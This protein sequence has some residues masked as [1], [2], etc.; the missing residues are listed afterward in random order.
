MIRKNIIGLLILLLFTACSSTSVENGE[1]V[2]KGIRTTSNIDQNKISDTVQS[3]TDNCKPVSTLDFDILQKRWEVKNIDKQA[4]ILV[5][6]D[7]VIVLTNTYVINLEISSGKTNWTINLQEIVVDFCQNDKFLILEKGDATIVCINKKDGGILWEYKIN[8]GSGE[9][10]NIC[11]DEFNIVASTSQG[12]LYALDIINGK[13]KWVFDTIE[14]IIT[15]ITKP[16]IIDNKVVYLV[17]ATKRIYSV[18][19]RNGEEIGNIIIDDLSN[20]ILFKKN[21]NQLV[22]L[23]GEY[24][25]ALQIDINRMKDITKNHLAL[26]LSADFVVNDYNIYD[27]QNLSDDN[28]VLRGIDLNNGIEIFNIHFDEVLRNIAI[29]DNRLYFIKGEVLHSI[30]LNGEDLKVHQTEGKLVGSLWFSNLSIYFI[31]E[32]SILE[33]YKLLKY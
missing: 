11:A 33:K 19:L 6:E 10:W 12:R 2:S 32:N 28:Y 16:I 3:E 23:Y 26:K 1:N 30:N 17:E 5:S 27:I 13:E 24:C 15:N 7:S 31:N 4:R 14:H 25:T 29:T 21:N 20:P 22:V 18:D 8:D 9:L